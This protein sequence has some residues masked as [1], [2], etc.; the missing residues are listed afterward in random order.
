MIQQN[1]GKPKL[2]TSKFIPNPDF[3]SMV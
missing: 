2:L 1:Y 3:G